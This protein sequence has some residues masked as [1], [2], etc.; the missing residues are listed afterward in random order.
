MMH[1]NKNYLYVV[2]I[3]IA[4]FI[5]TISIGYAFFR[6]SLTVNGVASTV[7]YYSGTALPTSPIKLDTTNNRYFVA[8]NS[9]NKVEFYSEVWEGDTYTLT[10]KKKF[11]MG[12]GVDNS[13]NFSISFSNPTVLPFTEGTVTTEIVENTGNMLKDASTSIDK[14]TLEPGEI[15]T[16]TMNFHTSITWRHHVETVKAT[17]SYMLQG[18][19]RYFY[20][21]VTYTT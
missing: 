2:T 12:V 3:V 5:F 7:D 1:K 13:T 9:Q 10:Y 17:V 14:I 8:D 4:I 6:E 21:I 20:F 11:G 15:A 19:P 18:K 16:I